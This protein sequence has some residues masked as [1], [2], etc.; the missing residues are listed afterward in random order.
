MRRTGPFFA[1]WQVGQRKQ[2]VFNSCC[3]D[4]RV[5]HYRT[6]PYNRRN[7]AIAEPVPGP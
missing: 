4:A 7:F 6:E 3:Q 2:E 5:V 1:L